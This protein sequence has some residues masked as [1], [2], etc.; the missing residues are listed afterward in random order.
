MEGQIGRPEW[1]NDMN[2][3]RM[4]ASEAAANLKQL[5]EEVG[6]TEQPVIVESEIGPAAIVPLRVLEMYEEERAQFFADWK[7]TAEQANLTAE[8]A[9]EVVSAAI[10]EVRA[11]KRMRRAS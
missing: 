10:A 6:K 1:V 2:A 11:E 7:R 8:E 4:T 9:N 5:I 3:K